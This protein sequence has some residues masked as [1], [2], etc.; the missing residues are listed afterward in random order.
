MQP[1]QPRITQRLLLRTAIGIF[2]LAGLVMAF[3]WYKTHESDLHGDDSLDTAGCVAA[4]ETTDDGSQA[5]VFKD[6]ANGTVIRQ[7][8]IRP[9]FEDRDLAWRPDGNFLFFASNREK[10]KF[11]MFRWFPD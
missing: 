9:D 1:T 11:T 2:V 5:L 4:I 7:P 6:D 10:A 8:N 3:R